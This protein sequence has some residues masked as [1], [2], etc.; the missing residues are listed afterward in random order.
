MYVCMCVLFVHVYPYFNLKKLAVMKLQMM[1]LPKSLL[2]ILSR[3]KRASLYRDKR[4][5]LDEM[6]L[7][8][9][10]KFVVL[11]GYENSYKY[12]HTG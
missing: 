12:L 6:F 11:L 3:W 2:L 8:N 7:L 5:M 1:K 4:S 9:T 10:L